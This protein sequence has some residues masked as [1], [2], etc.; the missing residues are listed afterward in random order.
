MGLGA[1][2]LRGHRLTRTVPV[3]GLNH[4]FSIWRQRPKIRPGIAPD[5]SL[6]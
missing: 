3:L 6:G 1:G 5:T 2:Y 4:A